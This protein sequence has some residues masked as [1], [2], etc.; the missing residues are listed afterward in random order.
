M[1]AAPSTSTILTQS[2][3]TYETHFANKFRT[4]IERTF[5][6]R[7]SVDAESDDAIP[8]LR[9]P[10]ANRAAWEYFQ[11]QWTKDG[12]SMAPTLE[13]ASWEA[14][15]LI[16]EEEE[17]LRSFERVDR[18]RILERVPQWA[19][20]IAVWMLSD[21]LCKDDLPYIDP[22]RNTYFD[23]NEADEAG[24][25]MTTEHGIGEWPGLRIAVQ[26]MLGKLRLV[27]A[28][29][30]ASHTS[31]AV[32]SDPACAFNDTDRFAHQ[33]WLDNDW[34]GRH[35]D[36]DDGESDDGDEA[37]AAVSSSAAT[38]LRAAPAAFTAQEPCIAELATRLVALMREYRGGGVK[39][40]IFD[41]VFV[42]RRGSGA[43][44]TANRVVTG[45]DRNL[46]NTD[47]FVTDPTTLRQE[48]KLEGPGWRPD[49][50]R[51]RSIES[52]LAELEMLGNVL[53]L[54]VYGKTLCRDTTPDEI[55]VCLAHHVAIVVGA[56][57]NEIER[58]LLLL[59]YYLKMYSPGDKNKR[60]S[61]LSTAP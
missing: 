8:P 1:V 49:E 6:D 30:G 5:P 20:F 31:K 54:V 27:A 15:D 25:V 11:Q 32:A 3:A 9:S 18:N 47:T 21:M 40:C 16:I 48:S 41:N 51:L 23:Y 39:W 46:K 22:V 13:E 45:I 7:R 35:D 42:I 24:L 60:E 2:M 55:P 33:F 14:L 56:C 37:D 44:K 36:E 19:A 61:K 50:V 28:R 34:P 59:F 10:D 52:V 29:T 38:Q 53:R 26:T 43:N 58:L 17:M 4:E 12:R 57:D